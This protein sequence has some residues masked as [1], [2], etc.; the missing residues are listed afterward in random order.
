MS[1]IPRSGNNYVLWTYQVGASEVGTN[2]LVGRK[3][4][5]T[6]LVTATVK[7][8]AF[9]VGRKLQEMDASGAGGEDRSTAGASPKT[10]WWHVNGTGVM[11]S[12]Q[13]HS[14]VI[15]RFCVLGRL[16]RLK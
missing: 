9:R 16:L 11:Y 8:T 4:S 1:P 15:R 5:P 6:I 2:S 3:A 13:T 14:W 10:A 7:F 12:R